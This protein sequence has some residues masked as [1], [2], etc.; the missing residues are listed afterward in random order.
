MITTPPCASNSC[1]TQTNLASLNYLGLFLKLLPGS[2]YLNLKSFYVS[3]SISI[4]P[5]TLI[6][7]WNLIFS[8]PSTIFCTSSNS[9]EL[10]FDPRFEY[11][12]AF[13]LYRFRVFY[14]SAICS[15]L[16]EIVFLSYFIVLYYFNN[17][18]KIIIIIIRIIYLFIYLFQFSYL[19]FD[20]YRYIS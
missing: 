16:F 12:I 5:L 9:L 11:I 2:Q 4:F 7:F 15:Y 10:T 14:L 20:L 6:C 1:F 17:I 19:Y 3:N 8:V 13:V 18:N